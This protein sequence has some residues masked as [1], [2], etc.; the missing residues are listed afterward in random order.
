MVRVLTPSIFAICKRDNGLNARTTVPKTLLKF[1]NT[2][3]SL[4]P[5]NACS[6]TWVY[7]GSMPARPSWTVLSEDM[8]MSWRR[9]SSSWC[10]DSI[11]LARVD[12]KIKRPDD[13]LVRVVRSWSQGHGSETSKSLLRFATAVS[14]SWRYNRISLSTL[15][16]STSCSKKIVVIGSRR[17]RRNPVRMRDSGLPVIKN[18]IDRRSLM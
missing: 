1:A 12:A 2:V 8:V 18:L 7:S 11:N 15:D 3:V 5:E 4:V 6:R 13:F 9:S 14:F 17:G 10:S 16:G